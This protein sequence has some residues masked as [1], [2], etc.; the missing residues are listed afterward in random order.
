MRIVDWG[1]RKLKRN[2]V[3]SVYARD[4]SGVLTLTMHG[5]NG[6]ILLAVMSQLSVRELSLLPSVGSGFLG[7]A[8]TSNGVSNRVLILVKDWGTF[9]ILVLATSGT[10]ASSSKGVPGLK[11]L[12]LKCSNLKL[13]PGSSMEWG[14][15]FGM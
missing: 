8:S 5:Q 15:V 11:L 4:G 14:S 7:D 3:K 13:E 9:W 12:L 6:H 10:R 2:V 1:I